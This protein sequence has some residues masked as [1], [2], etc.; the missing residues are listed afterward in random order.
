VVICAKKQKWSLSFAEVQ[1][2][3]EEL[4]KGDCWIAISLASDSRLILSARVGKHTDELLEEL[5]VSTEG[6]TDCKEWNTDGWG[7]YERGLP[8]EIL[9]HIGKDKTQRLEITNGIVRQQTGRWHRRQNKFGKLWEQTKVT[10][11][12]PSTITAVFTSI[13]HKL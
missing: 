3:P 1:C 13:S 8:P 4:E 9:H 2:L 10:T 5:V 11:I 7:G 6:K 12:S